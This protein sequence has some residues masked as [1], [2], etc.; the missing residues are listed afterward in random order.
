MHEGPHTGLDIRWLGGGVALA[1]LLLACGG[2][3][4]TPAAAVGK[5]GGNLSAHAH[6]VPQGAELCA[7]KEAM[8]AA[9]GKA[10]TSV[11]D[12]C[13]EHLKRDQVWR[14]SMTALAAYGEHIEAVSEGLDPETSGRLQAALTGVRSPNWIDVE[15]D[16]EQAARKAV[17]E[18][19]S[20]MDKSTADN[21]LASIVNAAAPHVKK[22]C[23]GLQPYLEEQAQAA[24]ELSDEIPKKQKAPTARRCAMIDNRPICMADN[25]VDHMV[26]ATE[27]GRLAAMEAGHRDASQAVAAFCAAHAKLDKAAAEG[28][29]DDD[30]TGRAV[31][32]EVKRAIP[33]RSEPATDEPAEPPAK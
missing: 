32:D 18:L 16:K 22:I 23:D 24:A 28:S 30:E 19:V 4:L 29:L 15:G 13:K 11:T 17:A 14:R 6:S 5:V 20:Q 21:D 3:G 8:K 25:V 1:T 2:G 31:V 33:E 12:P 27:F 9:G 7:L 26:Y 10:K